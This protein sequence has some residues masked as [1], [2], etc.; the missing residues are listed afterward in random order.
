MELNHRNHNFPRHRHPGDGGLER[1]ARH[2]LLGDNGVCDHL[3][4]GRWNL[5]EHGLW[6]G[7]EASAEVHRSSRARLEH[8]WNIRIDYQH[9]LRIDLVVGEKGGNLLLHHR[10]VCDSSL[11]RHVLCDAVEQVL[12]LPRDHEREA[13]GEGSTVG[14]QHQRTT[15]LLDHLQAIISAALQRILHLLRDTNRLSCCPLRHQAIKQ[16]EFHGN[17]SAGNVHIHH[18][19]FN[20][21]RVCH[22]RQLDD[23]VG[24]VA[25]S[26]VPRVA[27]GASCRLHPALSV[28]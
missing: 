21:Q 4:H 23:V 27:G 1:L 10:H 22:V 20:L 14:H 24:E 6:N 5:P 7:G 2:L 18:L 3:E 16:G 17:R 26:E 11:F 12:S 15:T 8:Q 28:L 13:A 19:L 9:P 25:V